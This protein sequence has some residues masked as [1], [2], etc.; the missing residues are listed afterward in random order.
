MYAI[1]LASVQRLLPGA[2]GSKTKAAQYATRDKI[3]IRWEFAWGVYNESEEHDVYVGNMLARGLSPPSHWPTALRALGLHAIAEEA[4]RST[5]LPGKIRAAACKFIGAAKQIKI[6]DPTADELQVGS[7][8]GSCDLAILCARIDDTRWYVYPAA[9]LEDPYLDEDLLEV[10]DVS[11]T[12]PQDIGDAH[13]LKRF[14]LRTKTKPSAHANAP[15]QQEDLRRKTRELLLSVRNYFCV[16]AAKATWKISREANSPFDLKRAAS[17]MERNPFRW[18]CDGCNSNIYVAFAWSWEESCTQRNNLVWVHLNHV[19]ASKAHLEPQCFCLS[20]L[21]LLTRLQEVAARIETQQKCPCKYLGRKLA[22]GKFEANPAEWDVTGW[23]SQGY[24]WFEWALVRKGEK[25][26]P[27]RVKVRADNVLYAKE[28]EKEHYRSMPRDPL[29]GKEIE[30]LY[31]NI[32]FANAVADLKCA[33][34][35]FKAFAGMKFAGIAYENTERP[36][37]RY[38]LP[39]G[40]CD[41]QREK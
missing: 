20:D 11:A 35:P 15:S 16:L 32:D 22:T 24:V 17:A 30:P 25:R 23:K 10:K 2:A 33:G 7:I 12:L 31:F 36:Q 18:Q 39:N 8:I 26:I 38:E 5:P 14:R 9:A 19:L 4:G 41:I 13:P 29:A 3:S 34:E 1:F 40:G 21:A 37:I 28:I 27:H 6:P